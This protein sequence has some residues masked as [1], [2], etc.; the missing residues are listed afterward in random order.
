MSFNSKKTSDEIATLA[1]KVLNDPNS[2]AEGKSLAGSALAQVN[3]AKQTGAELESLASA[4]LKS[5]TS[6]LPS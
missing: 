6:M 2:S 4:V 1:S 5:E 3:G